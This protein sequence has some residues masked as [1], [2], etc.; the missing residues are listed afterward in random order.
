MKRGSRAGERLSI[1]K[2][3]KEVSMPGS[4]L[5]KNLIQAPFRRAKRKTLPYVKFPE[6]GIESFDVKKS[7]DDF[8]SLNPLSYSEWVLHENQFALVLLF[9]NFFPT[10]FSPRS[11]LT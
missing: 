3:T 7:L 10:R 4:S 5:N 11:R 6:I 1:F 2:L 9:P 8:C